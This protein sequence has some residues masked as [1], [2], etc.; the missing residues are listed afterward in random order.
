MRAPIA[1]A[2]SSNKIRPCFL[3]ILSISFRCA[4][5]P[6]SDTGITALVFGV[7]FFSISIGSM[8]NVPT[9]MSQ[10]TG[11]APQYSIALAVAIKVN[12]GTMTSSPGLMPAATRPICR[13]VVQLVVATACLI[14]VNEQNSRSNSATLGPWTTQPVLSGPMIA[15]KSSW[16][17]N[18]LVMGNFRGCRHISRSSGPSFSINSLFM[19]IAPFNKIF[20]A[21]AQINLP[22]EPNV[23]PRLF[24]GP[25]PV[26]DK[27][28]ASWFVLYFYLCLGE[29][30][31][32]FREL[33]N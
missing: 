3:H 14:P 29:F 13:A 5:K 6:K 24:N 30:E 2:A 11:L 22:G 31:N 27:G 18:G 23:F 32:Q 1:Q 20:H 10:K 19:A 21:L 4:G 26:C 12:E 28:L 7:I 15:L 9:S 25:N 17:N 33:F 16:S 8:A